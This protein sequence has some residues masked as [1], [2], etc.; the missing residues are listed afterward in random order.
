VHEFVDEALIDVSS[1]KGGNGCV[2]FRR[3]RYAP[4]GGPDGGDGGRGGD[5]VFVTK[6]NLNTLSGLRYRRVFR[7]E[8]GRP[9]EGAQRHGRDGNDV[10]VEVPPGSVI[11]DAESGEI[12]ADL[13]EDGQRWVA[14]RGGRGGNGNVHY[15]SSTRQAPRYAQD[16]EPGESARLLVELRLVADIGLVGHPNAGKSSLL[17]VLT[18]ARPD[19]A[20]YPFTTKTPYLG[21][22]RYDYVDVT[23]ADIPG[24]LEGASDGVGLGT[25][26]LKHISR[27]KA[28][29]I[30]V[31][32]TDEDPVATYHGLLAE[33]SAYSDDLAAKSRVIVGSK[34]DLPGAGEKLERLSESL[35]DETVHGVSSVTHGGVRELGQLFLEL[36]GG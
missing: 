18:A 3:E 19:V 6:Q 29:A 26:F 16:G 36:A 5:V 27:T 24:I 7:A 22:F 34:M 15:K 1:G 14:L 21:V 32:L 31:D 2:S 13:L 28:L 33:L 25:S 20:D 12:L 17:R 35:R 9:G 10:V 4:K 8:N 30:V 23:I 11:R